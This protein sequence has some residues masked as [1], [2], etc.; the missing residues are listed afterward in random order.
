MNAPNPAVSGTGLQKAAQTLVLPI[1]GMSCASCVRRVEMALGKVPGVASVNVN[2]ATERA[3]VTLSEPLETQQLVQ[4]VQKMGYDVPES[5][6]VLQVDEMSCAS[7]VGRVERALKAV[8]GVRSASVNLAT[9]RATVSGLAPVAALLAAAE[10]AGY[11]ARVVDSGEDAG[12]APGAAGE[13]ADAHDTGVSAKAGAH[14]VVD[15]KAA[16][17]RAL[18]RDL[19]LAAALALPVFL[20]EMGGHMVPAFHHWVAHTIGTQNSWYLQFVLTTLVLFVP[21]L[22]FYRKGIPALLRGAPDMNSLVAVGTLAAWGFSTVATFL[23]SVLPAGSVNVYFESAAVIVVLIL[24]GRFLEARAKGRTS[25]AIQRLAGL[26]AR[27]AHVRRDGQVVDVPLAQVRA[28]DVVEVRPGERVPVDGEVIEGDSYVD[29]SMIT[30]EPVPVAK[31][32]GSPAVGGQTVLAQIIRMV[33]QAQGSKLPIQTLVDR[34]TM[35]FVPAVMTAALITFAIW[36]VFGPTPALGFALVN[37]VAVLIIACPCAMGLATPT[38]IMVGIGRGAELGVLFRKGEALQ[39]LKDAKVVAVDKTGTLTEG[40]PALTDLEV[41][42]GF[43]RAAVL[44]QVAA[45]ESRSEHPIARALVAAAG[46]G[47]A[48]GAGLRVADGAGRARTG[49]GCIESGH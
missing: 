18:W 48:G 14:S 49:A 42:P 1:E 5:T 4:A 34:V 19:W 11:P 31:T 7:C 45:L 8:P 25:E 26:Q 22:R 21:G 37:A 13:A 30:G 29:E 28:Q 39:L 36:M 10:K 44:A 27:T 43:G 40:R 24:V 6:V 35:W 2:L 17:Q 12:S 46:A 23:P 20:L 15:R 38:S 47:A 16:E 32:A 41:R 9:E 3:T 33:E